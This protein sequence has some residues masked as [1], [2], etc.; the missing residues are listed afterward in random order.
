MLW[1]RLISRH[2]F[3]K[4]VSTINFIF[5][6]E[7]ISFAFKIFGVGIGR[8]YVFKLEKIEIKIKPWMYI[9]ENFY[10]TTFF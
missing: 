1:N 8:K 5:F 9:R 3:L 2:D 4:F 10:S 6:W 7:V